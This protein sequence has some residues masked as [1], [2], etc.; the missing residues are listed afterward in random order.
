MQQEFLENV[1]AVTYLCSNKCFT[2]Y[3]FMHFFPF[4]ACFI[5]AKNIL[6]N[7]LLITH[8]R[9]SDVKTT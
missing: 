2:S 5:S 8:R 6:V 3:I 7:P 1:I 9:R 4:S